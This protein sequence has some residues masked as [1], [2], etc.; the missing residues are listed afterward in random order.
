MRKEELKELPAIVQK[1]LT[2]QSVILHKSQLTVL[3]YASD[4]RSFLRFLMVQSGSADSNTAFNKIAVKDINDD[5]I[6]NAVADDVYEYINF[7]RTENNN[8]ENTRLRKFSSIS[9]FY[10]WMAAHGY[11]ETNPME[12]LERPKHK[13]SLPK[14]LTLEESINLLDHID[15]KHKERDY[16]IITFFLNCGLRLSEL[17]SLN[18]NDIRPDRS[19]KVTG[20]GNKQRMVY[21]NDACMNAF[22]RYMKVRPTE[23]IALKD[24]NALFLS[25]QKRR[26]SP[27]TVQHIVITL[28]DKIGLGGQGFS[29]HKLRHT[30]ATLLYQHSDT[31]VMVLKELL[32]HES[33]ATTEIYT[34]VVNEQVRKAV[35]SSPLNSQ[36]APSSKSES[37]TEESDE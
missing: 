5:L 3:E 7:C 9:S 23:G 27:K 2:H 37:E 21:L 12:N 16:C 4:L 31:D 30:A 34:H 10:K 1:Y 35:E 36:R 19:M 29:T 22:E 20:K 17:V 11:V 6:Y 25:Q 24:K 15:G 13:K 28:F 18:Y 26:I 8:S 33:L 32:G 14:Y